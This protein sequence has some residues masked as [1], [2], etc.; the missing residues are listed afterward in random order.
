M[1]VE[2]FSYSRD[3][4][5]A[6]LEFDCRRLAASVVFDGVDGRY[7]AVQEQLLEADHDG[8]LELIEAAY[9]VARAGG[10]VAFG[11]AEGRYRSVAIAE[12]LARALRENG[13]AVVVQHL[14]L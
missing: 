8:V 10:H 3:G 9:R 14:S 2:S 5:P 6:V 7:L 13:F 11:C 4:R 12:M 1:I